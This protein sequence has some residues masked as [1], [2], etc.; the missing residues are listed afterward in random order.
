MHDGMLAS[1]PACLHSYNLYVDM[2]TGWHAVMSACQLVFLQGCRRV[3]MPSGSHA[4]MIHLLLAN[5][6]ACA[7]V[8]P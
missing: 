2:L 7:M 3:F 1:M 6:S 8:R 5:M 4:G